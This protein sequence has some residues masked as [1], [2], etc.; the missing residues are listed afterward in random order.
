MKRSGSVRRG[1][2][3]S[4]AWGLLFICLVLC[5]AVFSRPA[6]AETELSDW[7]YT[8]DDTQKTVTLRKYNGTETDLTVPASFTIE[9]EVYQ[10]ILGS[11]SNSS[12]KPL[13]GVVTFKVEPGVRIDYPNYLFNANST[14]ESVDLSGADMSRAT[15]MQGMFYQASSLKTLK[16]EDVN[17]SSVTNVR[18]LFYQASALEEIDLSGSDL[19]SLTSFAYSNPGN[20]YNPTPFHTMYN[21][22]KVDLSNLNTASLTVADSFFTIDGNNWNNQNH[23]E[24][25]DVTNWN[26]ENVTSFRSTFTHC[27]ENGAITITGLETLKTGKATDFTSMFQSC[28]NVTDLSGVGSFDM[29]NAVYLSN[30]FSGCKSITS[31]DLSRWDTSSVERIGSMFLS[32]ESLSDL[33]VSTWD[34]SKVTE[35]NEVFKGCYS[36]EVLDLSSWTTESLEDKAGSHMNDML[37]SL[38]S[39]NHS[40]YDITPLKE[41][42]LH[43]DFKF[44]TFPDNRTPG[45]RSGFWHLK[46][47][48]NAQINKRY[49][50]T[51]LYAAYNNGTTPGA[52]YSLPHTYVLTEIDPADPSLHLY[53]AH[54]LGEENTWEVHHPE[55]PFMT[56]CITTM[57]A[58]P[59]GGYYDRALIEGDEIYEY[60]DGENHGCEPLGSNMR[61][62]LITLLYY[63]YGIDAGGIQAKYGLSNQEYHTLTQQAIWTFTNRYEHLADLDDTTPYNK[64]YNELIHKSFSDIPNSE[65]LGLYVYDSLDSRQNLISLTGLDDRAHGGVRILKMGTESKAEDA[66]L[67][68]LPG[69]KFVIQDES[70]QNLKDKHGNDVIIVTDAE[71]YA[72]YWL[73]DETSALAEGKYYIEEYEAP[74]GYIGTSLY[75][76]FYITADNDGEIVTVG[77][78]SDSWEEEPMIF[79]NRFDEAVTGG[80]LIIRKV[81]E[82]GNLLPPSRFE[83]LLDG[84]VVDRL[85]TRDGVAQTGL[86]DLILGETY[87]VREVEAPMGYVLDPAPQTATVTED[88]GVVTLTFVNPSKKGSATIEAKKVFDSAITEGQF[89]FE[90]IDALSGE[91]IATASSKADGT[92]SFDVSFTADDLGFRRFTIREVAGS[93]EFIE[94]DDHE[95]DVVVTIADEGA[96]ALVCA[97]SYASKEGAVFTNNKIPSYTEIYRYEGD[98]PQAVMDTL[99]KRAGAYKNGAVVEPE[100]PSASEVKVAGG[101]WVFKGWDQTFATVEGADVTFVGTW[102]FVKEEESSSSSDSSSES[103][104]ESSDSSDSSSESS[105][106]SSSE[107]SESSSESSESSPESSPESSSEDPSS[108]KEVEPDPS[109]SEPQSS[110][111]DDSSKTPPKTGDA[112]SRG[113]WAMAFLLASGLV[114]LKVY[115]TS[116]KQMQ[117]G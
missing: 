35:M 67:V 85:T 102:E 11:S 99:P 109:S 72:T 20:R 75:Y 98:Y 63:G 82:S 28:D 96:E 100:S 115:Q 55:A 54:G 103:S 3:M 37:G 45:L 10:T 24:E 39:Y 113:L 117:R 64:A 110:T 13:N 41:I 26:T 107:S 14:I 61:E 46:E 116:K 1:L 43:P 111:P 32:C 31:L 81:D 58:A 56:Y 73:T 86:R 36:L 48:T 57:R 59:N 9:G 51:R 6:R 17:A 70:G 80:Q 18:Y 49:S 93:D 42:T 97:V 68:P 2:T 47:G 91:Q 84:E 8:K 112:A 71:G 101:T 40:D 78:S 52:D 105:S 23:L 88:M 104:S 27:G 38:T 30:M 16:M 29:H 22:K 21:L 114:L 74:R 15:S 90:L 108:S 76:S 33:N 19:S 69:V 5:L 95:E 89:T 12:N 94:Y 34:T 66:P 62:A 83:V 106:G 44:G 50:P 87:T 7:T 53:Q 77:V 4:K 60:M 25:I 79:T 92:V 65:K